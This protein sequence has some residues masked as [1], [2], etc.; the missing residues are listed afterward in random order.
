M[1][2]NLS[3]TKQFL[4]LSPEGKFIENSCMALNT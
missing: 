1:L 2:S 3:E 4:L